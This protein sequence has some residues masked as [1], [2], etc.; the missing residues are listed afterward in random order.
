VTILGHIQR[1][2]NP[3][4]RDRLLASRLACSAT[5]AAIAGQGDRLFGIR[6]ETVCSTP[7]ADAVAEKKAIDP[8]LL[9]L[10]N[11]LAG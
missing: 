8:S 6:G 5:R 3:T 2:G 11:T 4:A 1:G 7:I 10:V 9:E